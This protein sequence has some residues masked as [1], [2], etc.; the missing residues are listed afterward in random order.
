MF[1]FLSHQTSKMLLA[2]TS[3]SIGVAVSAAM[4]APFTEPSGWATYDAGANGVGTDPD[5]FQGAAFDGRYIYFSPSS[6]GEVLR[7]DT[8]GAF[9]AASAWATYDYGA[10]P[11]GCATQQARLGVRRW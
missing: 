1:I 11:N 10:D 3:V 6:N 9:I 8:T 4:A 7:Y 5:Q 2:L